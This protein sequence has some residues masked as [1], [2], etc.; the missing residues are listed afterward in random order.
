MHEDRDCDLWLGLKDKASLDKR[1]FGSWMRA[2]MDYSSRKSW[3]SAVG[4]GWAEVSQSHKSMPL[5]VKECLIR[6]LSG[7]DA[8]VPRSE[9]TH[10]DKA[11]QIADLRAPPKVL[12]L[13]VAFNEKSNPPKKS[14]ADVNKIRSYPSMWIKNEDCEGVVHAAWDL[15]PEGD[16][17]LNVMHKV[18]NCQSYLKSWNKNVFGNI[19]DTLARKR[20]LLAKAEI[21]AVSGQGIRQFKVLKEEINK[22]LDLEECMWSQ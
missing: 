15:S 14:L 22:L 7:M 5:P 16:P 4:S 13:E 19:R 3:S 12:S 2:E 1:Q 18:N 17:M 20:K 6:H 11:T 9:T 21:V 8:G 10:P